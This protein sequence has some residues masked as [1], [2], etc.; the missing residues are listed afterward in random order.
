[1]SQWGHLK[2]SIINATTDDQKYLETATGALTLERM[3]E[4]GIPEEV[5]T[6]C[7]FRYMWSAQL[8]LI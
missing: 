1:M 4:V 8:P 6:L 2:V 3:H 7:L 5:A